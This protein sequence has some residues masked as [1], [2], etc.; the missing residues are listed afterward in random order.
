MNSQPRTRTL[1]IAVAALAL[2][3]CGSEKKNESA[4]TVPRTTGS[5][6]A[7]T[8]AAPLD[9]AGNPTG[10]EPTALTLAWYGSEGQSSGLLA[11][12]FAEEVSKATDGRVSVEIQYGVADAWQQYEDGNV[13]LL[14]SPARSLDTLGVHSFDALV[15]P[16]VVN[17][18]DQADRILSSNS[19]TTMMEGLSVI[20]STGIALA[21][22]GERHL[23]VQGDEPLRSLSQLHGGIRV[24]AVGDLYDEMFTTLGLTPTH[25]LNG[26]DWAAAV[27]D[28]SAPVAWTST[29]L[30]G[31]VPGS[32][33]MGANFALGYEFNALAIHND[34]L[35]ALDPELADA[36]RTAGESAQQRTIDERVRES[37]AFR[38]A[39]ATGAELRALPMPLIS[40]IGR[41]LVPFVQE[42]LNADPAVKSMYTTLNRTAGVHGRTWPDEC[43]DS[44]VAPYEP[45]L[46]P[47]TVFPEGT[48]R[49][50][51]LPAGGLLAAGVGNDTAASNDWASYGEMRFENGTWTLDIHGRQGQLEHTCE[52]AYTLDTTGVI[53]IAGGGNCG[54]ATYTWSTT[55]DGITLE[56]ARSDDPQ[57]VVDDWDLSTSYFGHLIK[58]G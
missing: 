5:A 6:S 58:V 36:V 51:P 14:L 9:K 45:P 25:G 56:M 21:P 15:L 30:W 18:D 22:V 55:D 37:A 29:S 11:Q 26:E 46:P 16:F 43:H 42:R 35:A 34:V 28:G 50:A 39:C 3:A 27:A 52:A 8:T 49:S 4:A 33:R 40:E 54:A 44:T 47:S 19:V 48:Y 12:L 23:V 41:K 38:D 31:A 7:V 53:H 10:S 13:D 24:P 1:R 2:A 57:T 20:D 17:D 32:P